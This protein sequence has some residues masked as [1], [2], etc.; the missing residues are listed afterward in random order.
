M[1]VQAQELREAEE[2]TA[3]ALAKLSGVNE[4]IANANKELHNITKS[5]EKAKKDVSKL[6]EA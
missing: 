1:L 3:A 6:L 2:G 4:D 5:L